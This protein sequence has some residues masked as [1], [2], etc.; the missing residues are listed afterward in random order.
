ML[1]IR[2]S[3]IKYSS[4][5]DKCA[6]RFLPIEVLAF[7]QVHEIHSMHHLLQHFILYKKAIV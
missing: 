4:H 7:L 3:V 6:Y 1:C 5:S 2:H